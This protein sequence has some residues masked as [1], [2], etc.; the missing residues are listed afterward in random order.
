MTAK[1]L[2]KYLYNVTS[3]VVC[4]STGFVSYLI[5]NYSVSYYYV[6]YQGI[7]IYHDA[8]KII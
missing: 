3:V 5:F 1:E 7:T 4:L 2:F 6:D 8:K